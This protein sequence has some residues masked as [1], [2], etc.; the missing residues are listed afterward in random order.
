MGLNPPYLIETGDGSIGDDRREEGIRSEMLARLSRVNETETLCVDSALVAEDGDE[1][2][3]LV[4]VVSNR[5]K[6][7][8]RLLVSKADPRLE[9]GDLG[10]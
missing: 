1:G 6:N 5:P 8:S 2:I 3:M 10:R 9:G 4:P 7:C